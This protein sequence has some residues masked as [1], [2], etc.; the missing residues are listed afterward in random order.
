MTDLLERAIQE[1]K[2]LPSEAQDA[3]ATM[4]LEEIA[5]DRRWEEAFSRSQ[6]RLSEL[7]DKARADIRA[8]RVRAAGFDEL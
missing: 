4:I 8:G 3:I 6:D 7:A 1:I 5:D 2:R